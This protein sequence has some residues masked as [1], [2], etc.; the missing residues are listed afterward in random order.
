[1]YRDLA[2]LL[3]AFRFDAARALDEVSGDY[4]TTTELADTLQRVGNVPF[5]VGHHFASE[6]TTFGRSHGYKP[7][8][9]PFADA[10]RIYTESA[11]SFGIADA[12]I[13]ID[14]ALF[15]RS[16]SPQGMV[17]AS[18]G[19][20]GPQ[21]KEVQRMLTV[22]RQAL[23]ADEDWV[24]AARARL[25]SADTNRQAAFNRLLQP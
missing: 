3:K 7:S 18:Q 5:R 12:Q 22:Q 14:E 20:G 25:A 21:P 11:A 17:Q 9:I 8:E 1:M 6:L 13:P 23:V 2:T 24:K 15:H 10:Q 4:S 19:L 16:L